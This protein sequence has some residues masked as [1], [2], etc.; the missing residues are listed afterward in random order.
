MEKEKKQMETTL[1]ALVVV[2]KLPKAT[3][4]ARAGAME[5][6]LGTSQILAV[7]IKR[8]PLTLLRPLGNDLVGFDPSN[9]QAKMKDILV[10]LEAIDEN[11]SFDVF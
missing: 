1:E 4:T 11:I 3:D 7:M 8:T 2:T 10:T 6:S 5:H 9:K